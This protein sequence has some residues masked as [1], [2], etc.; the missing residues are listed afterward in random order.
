[1]LAQQTEF[2]KSTKKFE[3]NRNCKKGC[4]HQVLQQKYESP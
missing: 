2:L 1:M 3:I 4:S